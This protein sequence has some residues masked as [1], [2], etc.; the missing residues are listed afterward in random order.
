[1]Y[2]KKKKFHV[3]AAEDILDFSYYGHFFVE[4]WLCI[5]ILCFSLVFFSESLG[6]NT[7]PVIFLVISNVQ[8]HNFEW[9]QN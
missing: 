4:A 2:L 6:C 5:G 1:M 8:L 7:N 9:V 3:R